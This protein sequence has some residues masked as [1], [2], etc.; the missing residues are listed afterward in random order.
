MKTKAKKE[1]V[2]PMVRITEELL[3]IDI[4]GAEG[5]S[6]LKTRR[7]FWFEHRKPGSWI[8]RKGGGAYRQ[9]SVI[10][11]ELTVEIS[12]KD[13]SLTWRYDSAAFEKLAKIPN[14]LHNRIAKIFGSENS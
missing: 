8:V 14:G 7:N 11:I 9:P 1:V 5:K 13:G 6:K 10:D 3:K 2:D 4:C 12:V